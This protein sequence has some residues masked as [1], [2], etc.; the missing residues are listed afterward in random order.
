[1]KYISAIIGCFGLV[2]LSLGQ[3]ANDCNEAVPGCTTPSFEIYPPGVNPNNFDFGTG[4]VSNP[5]TNPGGFNAGCLL[6]GETSSTFITITVISS[7]TLEWFIQGPTGGCFDWIMWPYAFGSAG[8]TNSPTC[9]QLQN[10]T[11]APVACNWNGNCEGYTGMAPSGN[12][13]PGGEPSNFQNPLNVTAGQ[14]FLLCLSNY[15]GTSQNV[16]MEFTGTANVACGVSAPDQTICLGTSTTVTIATPGLLSPSFTWLVTNG[17]SNTSGGTNVTVTP[18][19]TTTY[20][21]EVYQ[22]ATSTSSE[23][24]DTAVFT[25]TVVPPPAPTAGPDQSVCLGQPIYLNGT[26]TSTSNSH[27]WQ[28]IV[29]PGMTP[30]ATASFSPNF[31]SL[32]PTVTV[33]QPGIYKFIHREIS[34]V[35]G[36]VRDTVVV[37]VTDL[38]VIPVPTSPSCGGYSDGSITINSVGAIEYSFD[39]GTTWQA[40]NT[41]GGFPAG[42]YSVCARN[43]QGC[44]KCANVTIV[45]PVAVTI[46][47]CNDTLICE[48]GTASLWASATGGTTYDFHWSHTASLLP[49]QDVSPATNTTYT[50]Y[51]T[52]E[53]G[54]QSPEETIEVTIRP[55]LSATITPDQSVCPG[56]PGT[57]TVTGS[58]GIGAPY[59][60]TW[61]SGQ[62]QS[63]V[64]SSITESPM[65]TTT[66]TVTVEDGCESTPYVISTQII[67]YPLPVPQIAVDEPILCEPAYFTLTNMT[68]PAMTAGTF[69]WISDGQEFVNANEVQPD[70]LYAGSYHVQL[71]VVSPDGCIDSTTFYD[72]LTVRPKPI[73]DFKWS[74]DPVTMFS[75]EVLLTNYSFGA[76]TYEWTI[77]SGSPSQSVSEDVVTLFP[78]GQTGYYAVTLVSTSD[79]GCWDSVTRI[80]PVL[81]EVLIYAPNTFTPDGDEFNQ[82]WRVYIEGIDTYDFELLIFNRWGELVWESHDV[83]AEWDGTYQGKIMPAGTYSWTI[84]AKDMIDD[85]KFVWQGHVYINR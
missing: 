46:A 43:A 38:T 69:W 73:A 77:E 62:V 6:S 55:S 25:I 21:V 1:M 5:T 11:L 37:T 23:F 68:D 34:T 39:N 78:D 76:S 28:A 30:P 41:Q 80:I 9:A 79:L 17:V 49:N 12:L 3:A 18:T 82:S 61:S 24:R 66:Y 59:T 85:E 33:N 8:P 64:S 10:G 26:I 32:T 72:Y 14:T 51:A 75:T 42:T 54:C 36:T 56:Y 16:N 4:T 52:N 48:N 27:S 47:A 45:D 71:I 50:V 58:G 13:P 44:T 63:G 83:T 22:A 40:S 74:P 53:S 19:V 15:S 2:F 57:I 20:E 67:A 70:S 31:S 60:Y 7:G 84:R 65:N 29:P 35:C 81:P